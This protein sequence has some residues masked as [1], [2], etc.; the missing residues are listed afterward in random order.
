MLWWWRGKPLI[1]SGIMTPTTIQVLYM[2]VYSPFSPVCIYVYTFIY[3]CVYMYIYVCVCTY[4]I[5]KCILFIY[6]T[7]IHTYIY[8][9]TC[10][11]IY[12]YIYDCLTPVTSR[13][14][15]SMKYMFLFYFTALFILLIFIYF[16][17]FSAVYRRYYSIV[18]P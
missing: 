5:S 10:I 9:H 14:L 12:L 18:Q 15:Y 13:P 4:I 6:S 17:V 2:C 7:Y 3:I 8:M 16:V 11:R 1:W